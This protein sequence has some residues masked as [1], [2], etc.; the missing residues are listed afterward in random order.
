MRTPNSKEVKIFCDKETQTAS[1][2]I[3]KL[4]NYVWEGGKTLDFKKDSP[5]L[6]RVFQTILSNS[7]KPLDKNLNLWDDKKDTAVTYILEMK[8]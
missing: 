4:R 7:V 6:K 1:I 2:R 5:E 8:K 3:F